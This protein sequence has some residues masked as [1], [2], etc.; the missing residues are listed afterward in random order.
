[1]Q[2]QGQST[3]S[4][5]PYLCN[6]SSAAPTTANCS[7]GPGPVFAK[8]GN[9]GSSVYRA[10]VKMNLNL[11]PTNV[12][13]GATIKYGHSISA[14]GHR[15]T[16]PWD[17][18]AATWNVPTSGA[19]WSGGTFDTTTPAYNGP[20][21]TSTLG[22]IDFTQL[23]KD[24]QRGVTPNNGLLLKATNEAA[25]STVTSS[26]LFIEIVYQARYGQQETDAMQTRQLSDRLTVGINPTFGNVAALGS[27]FSVAGINRPF[28]MVYS[29]NSDGQF[30]SNFLAKDTKLYIDNSSAI[31][32][33]SLS[34]EVMNPN[35][36]GWMNRFLRTP[37]GWTA[38]AG[39]NATATLVGSDMNIRY[40]DS[41]LTYRYGSF[42]ND[43]V[44]A[45]LSAITDSNGNTITFA[46][47]SAKRTST[48]TDT[49]GRQYTVA[50]PD[51]TSAWP[52]S[53]TDVAGALTVSLTIT[54]L[55]F[56]RRVLTSFV[57]ADNK[58]YTF[59]YMGT[60]TSTPWL[61]RI[62]APNAN[63]A[64]F[65]HQVVSGGGSSVRLTSATFGGNGAAP[66]TYDFTYASLS[67]AMEDPKGGTTTFAYD[68]N[69]RVTAITDP[70]GH[71]SSTSWNAFNK[72]T[73]RTDG[74]SA[75][76]SYSY[77]SLGNVTQVTAPGPAG[78][79]TSRS[80]TY[81]TPTGGLGDYQ[82]TTGTDSQGNTT[83][84]NYNAAYQLTTQ[85][86]PGG[87]GGTP[88][89]R[90]QGDPGISCTNA[91]P[92]Q[93]CSSVN[94]NGAVTNLTYDIA[95]NIA[96]IT[97]PAPLGAISFTYDA[98]GRVKS[99]TDG[100]GTTLHYTYDK[101]DRITRVSTSPSACPAASCVSY[102]YNTQ[103]DLTQRVDPSG[104]T[105]Y[106]YDAQRQPLTMNTP[107]G[108]T[109]YTY[110]LNGNLAT[111]TDPGGTVSYRYD[112]ADRVTAMWDQG[113]TC[114]TTPTFPNST[115]CTAF[116][117]DNADRRTITKYPNGQT[118]SNAYDN[119]GK[120]TGV[121]A[122]NS[123]GT[124]LAARTYNYTAGAVATNL[125][126]TVTDEAGAIT[127]YTYDQLNRV[128]SATVGSNV[129]SWTYDANNNR[130]TTT[131]GGVTTRAK[132]NAADQLCYTASTNTAACGSTPSGGTSYTYDGAGNLTAATS[133]LITLATYSS[134]GQTASSKTGSTTTAYTYSD[135]TS[136]QRTQAGG[137]SYA[138]GLLGITRQTSTTETIRF[139]RDP[140]GTLIA[141]RTG[142][143]TYYATADALGSTILLTNGSGANAG[144]YVYDTWGIV[145]NTLS[146]AAQKNPFRY[147]SGQQDASGLTK[148]G[149]RY[150]NPQLGRFTQTDPAGAE[151]NHY[152]YSGCDP[153]NN[154][155]PSGRDACTAA[156]GIAGVLHSVIW[157]AAASAAF[158][159]GA[160]I[161]AGAVVGLVVGGFWFAVSEFGCG[162]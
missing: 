121:T 79:Q 146:A 114:P 3:L 24:W 40:N 36:D 95:G 6:I 29:V 60:S 20:A 72:P 125:R 76:T 73:T 149:T 10:L 67:T 158:T 130:L 134:F 47:D 139:L 140:N 100:R 78:G 8:V 27:I 58:T 38:P 113:G 147:A 160:S 82:P 96:T 66:S 69:N 75:I 57:D 137:T 14:A 119:A 115:R 150:Y 88:T 1:M 46:Y 74:L 12:I 135:I 34:F 30:M 111:Y 26:N 42:T 65:V 152:A 19:T 143:D 16:Q 104:T 91:R 123:G 161:A 155:D 25:V 122:K 13:I 49:Q 124:T 141:M 64:D 156:A 98:L 85:A 56:G 131:V 53:I 7:Q 86:T 144:T 35:G 9:D 92:G 117:Y 17:T 129:Q 145:T 2:P 44:P 162:S 39:V 151:Q 84:Y 127:T 109:S 15:V 41:G 94:G 59:A 157:G 93:L 107:T 28:E 4:D 62:T 97:P 116:T 52:S 153:V 77:D 61:S 31:S 68:V 90:Y 37:S 154:I 87:A 99:K 126:Q 102:T 21:Y 23:A 101:L 83:T 50:Y 5:L 11:A 148:F 142:T 128:L 33:T 159:G 48:I 110:D 138:N 71:A 118:I 55:T 120:Q 51:A 22:F 133:G 132:Y 105:N 32:R 70:L 108:N 136:D 89:N 103:G 43:S 54:T 106:T 112:A 80:F 18:A 63:R 81:P 45:L